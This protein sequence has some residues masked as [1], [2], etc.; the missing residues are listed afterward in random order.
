MST[1]QAELDL[2]PVSEFTDWQEGAPPCVGWWNASVDKNPS[3]RRWWNG[4]FWSIAVYLGASDEVAER[5]KHILAF[6]FPEE[7][8][9]FRGLPAPHPAG[10]SY[11]LAKTRKG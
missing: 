1:E 3:V 4:R 8:I 5:N 6:L 2:V 11:F 10:Y 9:Y 7:K